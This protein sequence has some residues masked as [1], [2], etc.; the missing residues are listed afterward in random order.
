MGML[1]IEYDL[2]M[3][4]FL[5]GYEPNEK[6]QVWLDETLKTLKKHYPEYSK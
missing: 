2:W 5:R 3:D 4:A 1:K 6:L